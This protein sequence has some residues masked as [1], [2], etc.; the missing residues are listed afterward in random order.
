MIRIRRF[1]LGTATVNPVSPAIWSRQQRQRRI[2]CNIYSLLRVFLA[3]CCITD[4]YCDRY[5][6]RKRLPRGFKELQ[7]AMN[8]KVQPLALLGR[9]DFDKY[10]DWSYNDTL[11]LNKT[12][13]RKFTIQMKID[14]TEE[15]K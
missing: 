15:G 13:S 4:A 6:W 1:E 5:E 9:C 11:G 14:K 7:A 2:G 8:S 12:T 10:C 3:L